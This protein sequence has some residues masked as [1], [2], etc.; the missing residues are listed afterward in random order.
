MK[1]LERFLDAIRSLGYT[2]SEA[3][4]LYFVATH[5][6]YFV[7]RQFI[8]FAGVKWGGR[9]QTF[10]AK[11]EARGHVTWREYVG[12]GGVYHLVSKTLYQSIEKEDL[13]HRRPHSPE[14]IRTRLVL[15]DF[16]LA[17]QEHRYLETDED[18]VRY[19][20]EEMGL[21]KSVLPGKTYERTRNNAPILHFFVD[22]FPMFFDSAGD[23]PRALTLTYVDPG[24][25]S[26]TG[27]RNHLRAYRSLFAQLND[28]RFLYIAKSSVH[29][30]RAEECFSSLVKV[31]AEEGRLS[32]LLRYFRLRAAWDGQRYG[33]LTREDIAWLDGR[34]RAVRSA[35]MERTYAAW[36]A[37]E[38]K[39]EELAN[40]GAAQSRGQIRFAA[41]LVRDRSKTD[42]AAKTP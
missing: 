14:F 30:L 40:R 37:G 6:G 23:A 29:F 16:L 12:V 42:R 36:S 27:F 9:S 2:Q 38:V 32:D 22:R 33:E 41:Y 7:P 26:L 18:K 31:P 19:F 20:C 8:A 39:D 21:A 1:I 13:H 25:A 35:E 34:D 28:F 15:L 3:R 5:S 10:T 24:Q 4:F 17:N 11:L